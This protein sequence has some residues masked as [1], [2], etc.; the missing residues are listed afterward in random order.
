MI[1]CDCAV[2]T[3]ENPKNRRTRASILVETDRK[4]EGEIDGPVILID[5]ATEF[6]IQA[7]REGIRRLDAVFITHVHADHVHGLDDIRPLTSRKPLPLYAS[8][9]DVEE[10]RQRFGYIFRPTQVGGGKPKIRTANLGREGVRIGRVRVLPIPIKHGTMDIYGYRIGKF[11]YLTDC[12]GIPESSYRLLEGLRVLV[13]GALRHEPHPT[14]FSVQE[15]LDATK[16]ISP[17]SAYLTHICHRLDHEQ[18]ARELPAG[19]MPAFDGL[20]VVI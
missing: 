9:A 20:Q 16:R 14:H 17:G 6:R 15:A 5:T 10:I 2:C 18:L 7:I 11:A 13:I 8:R 1:G 12:N 4:P 3:S 19:V